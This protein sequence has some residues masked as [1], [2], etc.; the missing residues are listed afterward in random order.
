VPVILNRATSRGC[1]IRVLLLNP[2]SQQSA[3][4]DRDEGNPPGT[5]AARARAALSR[6]RDRV[7]SGYF[8]GQAP[9][10]R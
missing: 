6:C 9:K 4:I 8:S 1:L 7:I 10:E 3:V 5:L 2:G